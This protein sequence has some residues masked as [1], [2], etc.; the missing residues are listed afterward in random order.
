MGKAKLSEPCGSQAQRKSK[1][2]CKKTVKS[3]SEL[4][5]TQAERKQND[6]EKIL[7]KLAWVS[8]G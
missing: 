8:Q 2:H 3:D 1:Q 6:T 5:G 4:H 7:L